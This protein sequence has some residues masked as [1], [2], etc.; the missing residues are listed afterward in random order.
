MALFTPN[1]VF[2]GSGLTV[3]EYKYASVDCK[4]CTIDTAD[5]ILVLWTS[6]FMTH[7]GQRSTV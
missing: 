6:Q 2:T 7:D 3:S 5:Y 1:G 4:S